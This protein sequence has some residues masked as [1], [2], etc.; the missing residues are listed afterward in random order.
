MGDDPSTKPQWGVVAGLLRGVLPGGPD[1]DDYYR[2]FLKWVFNITSTKDLR[3]REAATIINWLMWDHTEE[4]F[5]TYREG[6]P[7]ASELAARE[8]LAAIGQALK[9][10]GD[11][12]YLEF[13]TT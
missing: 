7:F 9:E 4:E 11:H 12:R 2:A 1:E 6:K 3:K 5:D 8:Y 13:V 10:A